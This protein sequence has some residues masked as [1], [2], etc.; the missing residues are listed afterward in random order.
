MVPYYFSEAN[1]HLSEK[2]D[3]TFRQAT[4]LYPGIVLEFSKWTT[5]P[6]RPRPKRNVSVRCAATR[7]PA[8]TTGSRAAM[9]AGASSRGASGGKDA[10]SFGERG[11]WRR[12]RRC[13]NLEYVCKENGD[14]VVDVSRRNQCQ[15]CRFKKCLQVNMKREG[16]ICLVSSGFGDSR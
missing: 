4:A 15:A 16:N 11:N 14:C 12:C 7:R 10:T 3:A 5:R 9:A 6:H 2:I 1:T 13:R 8:S